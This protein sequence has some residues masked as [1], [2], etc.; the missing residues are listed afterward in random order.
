LD[1]SQYLLYIPLSLCFL[2]FFSE[3]ERPPMDIK[4]PLAYQ[5][6]VGLGTASSIETS[7]GHTV[8]KRDPKA[9]NRVRDSPVPAVRGLT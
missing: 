3:K 1:S 9:G 8:R 2:P 5:I 4:L 7:Q 6:A